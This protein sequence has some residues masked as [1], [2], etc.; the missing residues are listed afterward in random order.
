[1]NDLRVIYSSGRGPASMQPGLP[2]YPHARPTPPPNY[3]DPF[4]VR[5][6]TS[7]ASHPGTTYPGHPF[8][9]R[10]ASMH[11]NQLLSLLASPG[12]QRPNLH[13]PPPLPPVPQLVG[14]YPHPIF[15]P[16]PPHPHAPQHSMQVR[17]PPPPLH[18][19]PH[20][21][22]PQGQHVP[23]SAPAFS[24]TFD[25]P[26]PQNNSNLLSILNGTKSVTTGGPSGSNMMSP[27][28]VLNGVM[29]R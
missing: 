11:Q 15:G 26:P 24:P 13:T 1:M 23:A 5:P 18:V 29:H 4:Q 10:P 22:Y 16:P 28:G 17:G 6:R 25:L 14:P 2:H 8:A 20:S 27:P 12:P 9:G 21:L 19:M 7:Q 3:D